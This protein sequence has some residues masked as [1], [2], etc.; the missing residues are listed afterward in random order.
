MKKLKELKKGEFFT[1]TNANIKRP[2]SS[3]V[4]VRGDYDRVTKKYECYKYDDVN[5][6][7][8]F[9]GEMPVNTDFIF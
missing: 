4:W 6:F 8:E 7:R 2:L 1:I 3:R 9:R 5:H